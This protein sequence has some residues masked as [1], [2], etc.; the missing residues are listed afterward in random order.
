MSTCSQL[1][2]PPAPSSAWLPADAQCMLVCYMNGMRG[3]AI[4]YTTPG[5]IIHTA[6]GTGQCEWVPLHHSSLGDQGQ[7]SAGTSQNLL[8]SRDCR[9]I[10]LRHQ[11]GKWQSHFQ[12]LDPDG[13]QGKPCKEISLGLGVF[14]DGMVFSA[15]I[16]HHASSL[17]HPINS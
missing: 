15:D 8:Y 13:W 1:N 12:E 14:T 17:P 5:G 2:E 16:P 4:S 7:K 11:E 3:W 9:P 10:F 6:W